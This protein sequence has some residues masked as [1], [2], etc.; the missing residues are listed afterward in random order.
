MRIKH[1][2]LSGGG[3]KG[4]SFLGALEY[5]QRH[6]CINVTAL[7]TC[8]GSSAGA[9]IASLIVIG[10]TIAEIFKLVHDC[11]VGSLSE[12]DVTQLL[13]KFGIE[14]GFRVMSVFSEMFR[15]KGYSDDVTFAQLFERTRKRLV[16]T[17]TCVGKG[18]KYFDHTSDP[19]MSVLLAIRMSI[20]VPF[21]FTAVQYNGDYYVD[22]GVLDN[23][24]IVAL[25]NKPVAEVLTLSIGDETNGSSTNVINFPSYLNLLIATVMKEIENVRREHRSYNRH[26]EASIFIKTGPHKLSV[27]NDEKKE[28]FR[29]GYLAGKQYVNSDTYLLLQIETLP[30]FV[31]QKIWHYKH[32]KQ[33]ATVLSQ[34]LRRKKISKV[35]V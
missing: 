7:E 32:K 12:P 1:L 5:L 13:T 19:D 4:I 3:L 24:P 18:V 28:L 17:A 16:V 11:D 6:K 15:L 9:L 2:V 34:V 31:A 20:S 8:A 22:G 26:H 35:I 10:Y 33:Y 27:D 25:L 23:V 29:L 21:I 30:H 14:S